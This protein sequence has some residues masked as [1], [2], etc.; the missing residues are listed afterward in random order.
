MEIIIIIIALI[1]FFAIAELFGRSKHIGRWW[2]LLLL[3]TSF[4]FGILAIIFSPSA[5]KE[6]TKGTKTHKI[7]GW[8]SIFFGVLNLITLSAIG[9]AFLALGVY[10]I[11]LSE[12]RIV[13]ENPEFYFD[14]S[15]KSVE[16]NHVSD[17]KQP[18]TINLTNNNN[19]NHYFVI[20]KEEQKGPYSFEE[21]K[22]L[23]INEND[24]IWR[25]GLEKWVQA[26]DLKEIE[27]IVMYLP[28]KFEHLNYIDENIKEIEKTREE[29]AEDIFVID[30]VSYNKEA[31]EKE[32]Q[33]GNFFFNEET[34]VIDKTGNYK[35][36]EEIGSLKELLKYFPPKK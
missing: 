4:I 23:K 13:N 11:Q 25:K 32:L 2:S 21:L 30:D 5:K 16:S 27:N 8:I 10:L 9:F 29:I 18:K 34:V 33:E 1:I 22:S 28:P 36:I 26:K 24:F 3:F 35:K 7:W 6:P 12:G 20:D 31:L 17:I 15:K 19:T 14:S